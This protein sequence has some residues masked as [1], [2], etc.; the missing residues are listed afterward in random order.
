M[1]RERRSWFTDCLKC[2]NPRG[3]PCG[4]SVKPRKP[5][6]R[7]DRPAASDARGAIVVAPIGDDRTCPLRDQIDAQARIDA[8]AETVAIAKTHRR[9]AEHAEVFDQTKNSLRPL[10]LRVERSITSSLDSGHFFK[11]QQQ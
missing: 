5:P 9:G 4:C 10:R 11:S 2:W 3:E 7:P 8:A 1:T 6:R